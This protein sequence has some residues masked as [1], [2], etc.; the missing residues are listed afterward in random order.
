MQGVVAVI[1]RG[2]AL[3]LQNIQ[4]GLLE[5]IVDAPDDALD[6]SV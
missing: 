4:A 6:Y 1:I 2:V 5:C 3:L